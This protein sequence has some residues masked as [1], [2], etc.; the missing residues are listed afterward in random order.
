MNYF[1]SNTYEM[2]REIVNFSDY[3]SKDC[4]LKSEKDFLRDILYGISASNSLKL[5]DISR[6]LKEK[7]KLD[8]TIERLSIHLASD[9]DGKESMEQNYF[10]FVKGMIPEEPVVNFDNS[11]ICKPYSTKL[12]YLDTVIDASD[13]KKEKKPGYPVVNAVVDVYKR[14]EERK[15]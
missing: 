15:V 5:S 8:N 1:T 10:K 7:I 2:K 9:M 3:L 14:Q 4:H 11:D 6:E 13:P 12:E